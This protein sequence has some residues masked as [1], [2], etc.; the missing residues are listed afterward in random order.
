MK[1]RTK[2]YCEWKRFVGFIYK[3]TCNPIGVYCDGGPKDLG[4]C[5]CGKKIKEV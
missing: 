2:K 1:K 3:T 5:F 4:K